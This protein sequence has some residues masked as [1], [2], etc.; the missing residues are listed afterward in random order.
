MKSDRGESFHG[1]ERERGWESGQTLKQNAIGTA[2]VV[3]FVIA[4]SSPLAAMTGVAPVIFGSMGIGAPAVYVIAGVT[5][6]LF[7]VGYTAMARHISS[8]AGFA[9]YVGRGL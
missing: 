6:G 8:A 1:E 3:F 7:A 5:L 2:G 9:T 4:A